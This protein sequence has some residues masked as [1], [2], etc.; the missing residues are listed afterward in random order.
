LRKTPANFQVIR[1]AMD[2]PEFY[3][4]VGNYSPT[5]RV[6]VLIG[7]ELTVW[8]SL[9]I[10]EFLADCYPQ[11]RLWPEDMA[12]RAVARSIA[13]EMHSGLAAMRNEFP[14]NC[15]GRERVVQASEQAAMDL[16]RVEQWIQTCRA[17]V[18][19]SGPL[20]GHYTITD[21]MLIPVLLRFRTYG[22]AKTRLS[23]EYLEWVLKDADVIDWLEHAEKEI[24][25]IE[26]EER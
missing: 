4:L 12:L 6:P 25:V 13:A 17:L 15:R 7:N 20:L 21:S 11:A 24:E 2:T 10:S 22:L 16:G 9:A 19:G 14:L 26:H 3:D 8:D 18:P 5:G 1:L 23:R